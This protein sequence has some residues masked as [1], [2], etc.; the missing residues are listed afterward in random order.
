[1]FTTPDS[2]FMCPANV[3]GVIEACNDNPAT[4]DRWSLYTITATAQCQGKRYYF[5]PPGN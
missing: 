2:Y 5:Y 1:M 3:M 4:T